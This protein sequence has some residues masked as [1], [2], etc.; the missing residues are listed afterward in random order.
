[1]S[2]LVSWRFHWFS[3]VLPAHLWLGTV[4]LPT[5]AIAAVAPV[6][7]QPI[8]PGQ[9]EIQVAQVPDLTPRPPQPPLPETPLPQLPPPEELLPTPPVQPPQEGIPGEIPAQITVQRYQ[10]EGSTVFSP[11]QFEAV[12]R[13][14]TGSVSFA[15][16]LEA[17]T[18][19][20]QLYVQN[21]YVTSGAILP[22]QTI[23]DGVVRIQVIEGSLEEITVRGNRRL[24]SSYVRSRLRL[25][26]ATPL[27]ID[28]LLQGLQLLQLDPLIQTISA[29]LQAGIRPG[30]N[31]LEVQITEADVFAITPEINNGRSPSVG[32][33]R[34]QVEISHGNLLGLGDR[35]SLTY[36]NTDGS[37]ALDGSYTVPVNPRNGT[38]RLAFGV[39]S[40]EIIAPPFNILDIQS[41]SRYYE[42]SYRQPLLQTPTE[43][44]AVGI[45]A[46]R[47]ESRAE[48]DPLGTGQLPF[49]TLGADDEGRTRVSAV[50]LFQE[51][52]ERS[53]QHVLAFRSQFSVGLD[54]F[55]STVNEDEPDS[56]FVSWRGQGQWVRLLADETL[57]LV[58]GDLQF[59][60][61]SLLPLE[62]FGLGGGQSVRG[63]RQD[64]LLTDSGALLSAE[65]RLPILRVPEVDGV[66]QIA[67]FID[68]GTAWNVSGEAPPRSFLAGTGLGLIW[69]MGD[70]FN[71]RLDWG[72]PL[73]SIDSDKRTWQENGIYFSV[74]FAAF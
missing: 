28:Q 52:T 34:R 1:M 55:N 71:A 21:G 27:N 47:Q 59:T 37:N 68:L 42:L 61:D 66:L 22:P 18:A 72:I 63:Y 26:G 73:V 25:A 48:F 12:T 14:F 57:V 51:W 62:Q 6:Q 58:R 15:S 74:S 10:V 44:L 60:G 24:N 20:T 70:R 36:S 19:V 41:R 46:S 29:D 40:S 31:R 64:A 8:G 56:R 17:R 5:E 38:V 11:E 4:L 39:S 7:E 43:E 65:L 13:D 49:P 54:A 3:F 23:E 53:G 16:L 45:T 9:E 35:A 30:T 2:A 32:S 50:R 67:P 69:R 33:F